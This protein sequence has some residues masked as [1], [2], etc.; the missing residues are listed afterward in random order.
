MRV[1]RPDHGLLKPMDHPTRDRTSIPEWEQ[2][3]RIDDMEAIGKVIG[4]G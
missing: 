1:Q 3:R 4:A 2:P